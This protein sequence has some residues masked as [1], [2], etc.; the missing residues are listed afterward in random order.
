M[1]TP[2]KNITT[3]E[4]D[5]NEDTVLS[6]MTPDNKS[7]APMEEDMKVESNQGKK[8]NVADV[9]KES[10]SFPTLPDTRKSTVST[11]NIDD[12]LDDVSLYLD[13]EEFFTFIQDKGEFEI[14]LEGSSTK[15]R[16]YTTGIYHDNT[17]NIDYRGI[18][19]VSDKMLKLFMKKSTEYF[20]K[21][22][23]P[24]NKT[25]KRK[26][27]C[28]WILN[29]RKKISMSDFTAASYPKYY[30][31][32]SLLP[33]YDNREYVYVLHQKLILRCAITTWGKVSFEKSGK[34]SI[35]LTTV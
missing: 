24:V 29:N 18:Y 15:K 2:T 21:L 13:D 23:P 7:D 9:S 12:I 27:I 20:G 1:S 3:V 32:L 16:T 5:L 31:H 14:K 4:I 34:T 6:P 35:I 10:L 11:P 22:Q 28:K 8:R 30:E 33:P 19:A 26:S 25:M 17:S